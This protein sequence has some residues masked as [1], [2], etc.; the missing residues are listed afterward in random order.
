[1]VDEKAKQIPPVHATGEPASWSTAREAIAVLRQP[2]VVR[3][4]LRIA[5]LVGTLLSVV[6]QGG[7]ILGGDA[8]LV[9]WIRVAANYVIPLCVSSAGVLSGTRAPAERA[10]EIGP[11]D[12]RP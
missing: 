2:V 7:V 11:L 10:P 12:V 9:T 3:R 1:M 8:T 5:L 4:T 6:N